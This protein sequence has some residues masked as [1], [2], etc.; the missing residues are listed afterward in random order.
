MC[1]KCEL[2]RLARNGDNEAALTLEALQDGELSRIWPLLL[3][4]ALK[5]GNLTE[6][7][8]TIGEVDTE[9]FAGISIERN[10]DEW[11]ARL[12]RPEDI[13]VAMADAERYRDQHT[14][15]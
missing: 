13:D 15:N 1:W 5:A 4:E 10:D 6:L 11:S 2:R 7:K 12:V 14:V 3:G 8:I 9:Q